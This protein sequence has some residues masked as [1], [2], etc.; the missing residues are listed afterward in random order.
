M[1]DE[2]K[3]SRAIAALDKAINRGASISA[4]EYNEWYDDDVHD[5]F[6]AAEEYCVSIGKEKYDVASRY[7]PR[8]LDIF[9]EEDENA[10]YSRDSDSREN[11][12]RMLATIKN[13]VLGGCAVHSLGSRLSKVENIEGEFKDT[14]KG[15]CKDA[16]LLAFLKGQ[17]ASDV[18]DKIGLACSLADNASPT[19]LAVIARDTSDPDVLVNIATNARSGVAALVEVAKRGGKLAYEEMRFNPAAKGPVVE[20]LLVHSAPEV[21]GDI[22]SEQ[23][24]YEEVST[25]AILAAVTEAEKAIEKPAGVEFM[26]ANDIDKLKD[27]IANGLAV[28]G[29]REGVTSAVA[30]KIVNYADSSDPRKK[31]A[32]NEGVDPKFLKFLSLDVDDRVRRE[33]AGNPK[34]PPEIL[35]ALLHD[36]ESRVREVAGRRLDIIRGRRDA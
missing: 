26:D 9:S 10:S 12:L 18:Y 35:V 25:R 5:A 8:V 28:I 36:P 13:S 20:A 27:V 3:F 4:E 30:M 2:S 14:V 16:K 22:L 24:L 34:T 19:A 15:L 11:N 1:T 31:L 7:R 6:E 33:V 29:D 23:D 17:I 32:S 21:K